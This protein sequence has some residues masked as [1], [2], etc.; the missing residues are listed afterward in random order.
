M[1]DK[2][3]MT[4]EIERL[5]RLLERNKDN[6]DVFLIPIKIHWITLKEYLEKK[7]GV[8]NEHGVE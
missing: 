6:E 3:E 2:V 7:V 1:M 4:D 5:G 8:N